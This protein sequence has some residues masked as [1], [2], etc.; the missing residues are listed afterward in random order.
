MTQ[1]GISPPAGERMARE[2]PALHFLYRSIANAS[3]AFDREQL[4]PRIEAMATRS[5]ELLRGIT[6]PTLFVI[7]DE[8][9]SYP[10]FVSQALAGIMPNARVEQVATTGHSVAYQRADAFNRIVDSFLS[11]TG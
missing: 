7:G 1:R 6:I 4:R 10:A 5:P 9:T 8:D 2:Q 11:K 3:A